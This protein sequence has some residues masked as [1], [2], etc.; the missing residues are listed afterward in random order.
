M[1]IFTTESMII[2]RTVV[3]TKYASSGCS[4][5]VACHS[6]TRN[7]IFYPVKESLPSS[8]YKQGPTFISKRRLF[9]EACNKRFC[10]CCT[11]N[12]SWVLSERE[13]TNGNKNMLRRFTNNCGCA[14]LKKNAKK[15]QKRPWIQYWLRHLKVCILK[16]T[17]K[18]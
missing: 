9:C 12:Q 18:F 15:S 2:G 16:F 13:V 14:K 10:Y 5:P 8:D 6:C 7:D 17:N 1:G 3:R 4:H 11:I